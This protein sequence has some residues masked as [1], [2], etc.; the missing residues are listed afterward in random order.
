MQNGFVY[1]QCRKRPHLRASQRS[2]PQWMSDLESVWFLPQV[3]VLFLVRC[4]T[5]FRHSD[6][7]IQLHNMRERWL[8]HIAERMSNL[9]V[10]LYLT[11]DTLA[12]YL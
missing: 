12:T 11:P 8:T 1:Y 5:S 10:R 2:E 9:S 6:V 3:C 7:V 4:E